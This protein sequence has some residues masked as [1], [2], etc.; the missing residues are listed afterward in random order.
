MRT[1]S[2]IKFYC[3]ESKAGKNGQAPIE[4]SII[5]NGE[6]TMLS[7]PYKEHPEAFRKAVESRK[8]NPIKQYL[9]SAESKIKQAIADIMD[10][11]EAVTVS[12][13]KMYMQYGG[14]RQ[15]AIEDLFKDFMAV[16][17][18]RVGQ[19]ISP[20]TYHRYGLIRDMF[21]EH[22][23][24][25]LSCSHITNAVIVSFYSKLNEQYE[26]ST[27]G[28]MMSKLRTIIKYGVDNGK[29]KINPFAMVHISKGKAKQE[30]LT[31]PELASIAN[32]HFSI[33]RLEQVKDLFLFQASCGLSYSDMADLSY[34]DIRCSEGIYY[35]SKERKKTGQAFCA[36]VLP[37]GLEILN[38]YA[39]LP[40]LSN[41]KYNTYLKEIQDLCGL[42]KSLHTHLA[43]KTYATAL[44]RLGYNISTISRM[45][46]HSNTRITESTYSF[47]ENST[48]IEE[49]IRLSHREPNLSPK[50]I[51]YQSNT[52]A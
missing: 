10:N 42:S 12:E 41:Q 33:A 38:K 46:G 26:A 45:L 31:D 34:S 4:V 22:I 30:Y 13:I 29:I 15:Y 25:S 7:L 43:R 2:G 35:I 5:I 24:K 52:K 39:A 36:I 48:I 21:F 8:S 14:I 11:G 17:A 6:R 3:R 50:S 20:K 37:M 27:S 18:L 23:D 44:R 47:I 49:T 40:M 32:R 1:T 16:M 9:S 51:E 28:S 19:G